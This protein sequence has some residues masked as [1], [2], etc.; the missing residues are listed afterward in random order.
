MI[1]PCL[2]QHAAAA[3][4][5]PLR[6]G[7]TG[8]TRLR[9]STEMSTS[10][11]S[12]KSSLSSL[13]QLAH[14]CAAAELVLVVDASATH[15]GAALQQRCPACNDWEPLRFFSKK[16]ETAQLVYSTF[17]RELFAVFAGIRHFQNFI[18][19]RSV[20]IRTDH[21]PLTYALHRL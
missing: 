15:I 12:A 7:G 5:H 3:D 8:A 17:D 6:S 4:Q 14:P 20:K 16:L 18:E 1:H 13:T 9:W 11:S 21:K 10:F 19:G 2:C